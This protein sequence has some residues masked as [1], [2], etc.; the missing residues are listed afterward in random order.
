MW[1][2]CLWNRI[3]GGILGP[4]T[5]KEARPGHASPMR[6][7]LSCP[8]S[9]SV[10]GVAIA[11]RQFPRT[12]RGSRRRLASLWAVPVG[13]RVC[14]CA[15]EHTRSHS[16]DGKAKGKKRHERSQGTASPARPDERAS[17]P[18]TVRAQRPEQRPTVGRK[19]SHGC[20]LR[21]CLLGLILARRCEQR[22]MKPRTPDE[23]WD[24]GSTRP[25]LVVLGESLPS[26]PLG[27]HRYPG[28]HVRG[29]QSAVRAQAF[30]TGA[31]FA[32][33][34]PQQSTGRT[35]VRICARW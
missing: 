18:W 4:A 34:M 27:G 15:L 7:S 16:Q 8:S 24:L 33:D 29:S 19:P 6:G 20:L 12:C 22:M 32:A 11:T 17:A 10:T 23:A 35:Q 5:A 31:L 9:T 1:I 28:D 3:I 14:L 21:L 13:D 2:W 26:Q 30:W 25:A